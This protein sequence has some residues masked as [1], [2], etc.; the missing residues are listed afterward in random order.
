MGRWVVGREFLFLVGWVESWEC[1]MADSSSEKV[2]S[3][4]RIEGSV[5]VAVYT[6][7]GDE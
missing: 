7:I 4:E 6:A 5:Q 3:V 2:Q 1:E